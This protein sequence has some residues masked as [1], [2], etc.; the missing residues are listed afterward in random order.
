MRQPDNLL[1]SIFQT[2]GFEIKTEEGKTYR[3]NFLNAVNTDVAINY[4]HNQVPDCQISSCTPVLS[5]KDRDLLMDQLPKAKTS[6]V[7]NGSRLRDR[8]RDN[9]FFVRAKTVGYEW[10]YAS[11]FNV[12][13]KVFPTGTEQDANDI[14]AGGFN[15]ETL[16][17][18]CSINEKNI[19]V[20]DSAGNIKE[21]SREKFIPGLSEKDKGGWT[22][23]YS[24]INGS[25]TELT[26]FRNRPLEDGE[27][28][29]AVP[30]NEDVS[31]AYVDVSRSNS[32]FEE[33]NEDVSTIQ[34][35]HPNMTSIEEQ[36]E[37]KTQIGGQNK[38][39]RKHG[40]ERTL[41]FRNTSPGGRRDSIEREKNPIK[42]FCQTKQSKVSSPQNIEVEQ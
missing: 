35:P 40:E 41:D 27:F 16:Y 23:S 33:Y 1:I 15:S 3:L 19:S 7:L 36:I 21:I 42:E 22:D 25:S 17:T 39:F 37:S 38:Q 11:R 18:I 20:M 28:I 8:L 24:Y 5:Q 12:G 30:S 31:N 6:P 4:V 13:D 10:D 2:H 29:H 9:I 26:S 14:L 34:E 32:L